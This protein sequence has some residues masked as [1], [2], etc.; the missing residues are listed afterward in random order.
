MF[1]CLSD[2]C[3]LSTQNRAVLTTAPCRRAAPQPHHNLTTSRQRERDSRPHR[4][5]SPDS[6][7][8]N[9][10]TCRFSYP[11]DLI[12]WNPTIG[13][14]YNPALAYRLPN[15]IHHMSFHCTFS[16]QYIWGTSSSSAGAPLVGA[17]QGRVVPRCVAGA[18]GY[19][20]T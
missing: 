6:L 11:G 5:D 2:S 9:S 7:H 4:P 16:G 12:P 8:T 18:E 14:Q 17:L 15:S 13:K 10:H 3:V 19:K 1:G 20:S